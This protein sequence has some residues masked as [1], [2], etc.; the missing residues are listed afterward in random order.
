M[1]AALLSAGITYLSSLALCR[2]PPLKEH[3]QQSWRKK[4]TTMCYFLKYQLWQLTPLSLSHLNPDVCIY[5]VLV[6]YY[7]WLKLGVTQSPLL[8]HMDRYQLQ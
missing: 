3:R 6:V 7:L 1:V 2:A 4:Y 5:A 8:D